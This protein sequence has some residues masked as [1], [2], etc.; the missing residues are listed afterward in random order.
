[1]FEKSGSPAADIFSRDSREESVLVA[2]GYGLAVTVS[3]G[4]LVIRDGLGKHRRER[5]LTRAQRTVRRVV[6]LGHTGHVTLEAVRWCADTSISLLQ[7]DTDGRILLTAAAEGRDD[8]RLRRAQAAA[9]NAPVGLDIT[10]G[11]LSAK[12]DGQAAVADQLLHAPQIADTITR[13]ADELRHA[14][15]LPAC[16]DLEAQASN[17]YFGAWAGTV[18]CRFTARDQPRM[19]DHWGAF[20]VRRS[21]INRGKAPGSAADPINALLNYSYALAEAECRLAVLAVG[22]DPGLGIVHTD[23]KARDSL[24]LDLL[25]PLRPLAERHVLQLLDRRHLKAADVHE[26]RTGVCRVLPPLT[27][28]LAEALP[29]Y[30]AAAAPLAEQVAHALARTS[31]G[32]ISLTT[33]LSR[34]NTTN[35]QT[36]G[37]RSTNRQP[38][39]QD[40]PRRTCRNCGTDLYG[41]ARK[42]CAACW[43][44]MRAEYMRQLGTAR[45]KP[46]VPGK[47]TDEELSGGWTLQQYQTKILPALADV[48]LP[49]IERATG[50]S[51]ATCSRLR[52]GLQVPNPRHWAAL[53]RL[54]ATE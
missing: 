44:V 17:V 39:T 28:E 9:P 32:K 7:I 52:R 25:E 42:L 37:A 34:T 2:D 31:P 51:N 3:R 26:T 45:A 53:V 15:T 46:A 22:L 23:V 13:L 6:L 14:E 35:A 50:L 16:R 20:A 54:V 24:A 5:R 21:P 30:A 8:P 43:P 18:T 29:S 49:V 40:A 47:R 36:R 19:P 10:R 11:L 12:L 48:P 4:H 38:M 27:H 41:S 1:L 33:P